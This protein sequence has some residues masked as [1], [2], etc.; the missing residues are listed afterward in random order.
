MKLNDNPFAVAEQTLAY[1]IR[2]LPEVSGLFTSVET[3]VLAQ[4][5]ESFPVLL[6]HIVN[7]SLGQG[8]VV[9]FVGTAP[10]IWRSEHSR[11]DLARFR[12]EINTS[13]LMAEERMQSSLD[14][15]CAIIRALDGVEFSHPFLGPILYTGTSVQDTNDGHRVA[16]ITF[17][18]RICFA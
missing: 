10:E 6:D 1:E 2:T 15:A 5:Q 4:S 18:A 3:S 12:V 9:A 16:T 14:T 8:I 13:A 7:Q 17:E 11:S